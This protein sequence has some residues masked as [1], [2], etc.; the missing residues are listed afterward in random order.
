MQGARLIL[1]IGTLGGYST[2]WLARS[3][4]AG[5]RLVT[6]EIDPRHAETARANLV[7]AGLA[8]VVELHLGPALETLPH[9]RS[10]SS[11]VVPMSVSLSIYD[12]RVGEVAPE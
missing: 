5:G 7:R 12:L 11:N 2:I 10:N 8:E 1:E 3:L 9:L 4:P 6:L